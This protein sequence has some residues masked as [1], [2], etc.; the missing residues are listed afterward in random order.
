MPH[1]I[2]ATWA[3]R[4]GSS[5]Q[6]GWPRAKSSQTRRI[7]DSKIGKG[8]NRFKTRRPMSPLIPSFTAVQLGLQVGDES[9]P[10]VG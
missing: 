10:P 7:M 6:L 1:R 3:I 9:D 2:L 4:I 5:G 8:Q